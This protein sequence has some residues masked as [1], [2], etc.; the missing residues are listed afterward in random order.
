VPSYN[1]LK[2]QEGDPISASKYNDLV[3]LASTPSITVGSNLETSNW[4]GTTNITF[5]GVIPIRWTCRVDTSLGYGAYTC[6]KQ[7]ASNATGQIT[8]SDVESGPDSPSITVVN[9]AQLAGLT[10]IQIPKD[11]IINVWEELDGQIPPQTVYTTWV[12]I[13]RASA[14]YQYLMSV[15]DMN[16]PTLNMRYA[17]FHA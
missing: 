15:D 10:I 14:V 4:D 13:P 7:F 2:V 8:Y 9:K 6:Y 3:D 12:W 17:S 1:D 5:T 11:T 16:P